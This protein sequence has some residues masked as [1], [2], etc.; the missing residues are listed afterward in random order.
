MINY[1][2]HQIPTVPPLLEKEPK[3]FSYLR[4]M[5]LYPAIAAIALRA[6]FHAIWRFEISKARAAII[7]FGQLVALYH[8]THRAV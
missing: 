2:Y 3:E 8:G 6:K 7:G 1:I 4:K 5:A